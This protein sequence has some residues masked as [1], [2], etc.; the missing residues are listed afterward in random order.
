MKY[1][2]SNNTIPTT[3]ATRPS[4]TCWR[5]LLLAIGLCLCVTQGARGVLVSTKSGEEIRGFLI[6]QD[7]NQVIV[8]EIHADGTKA[9]RR[10]D[11]TEIALIVVTVS[12]ADLAT[13]KHDEPTNY[14]DLAEELAVKRKDPDAHHA[15]LRLYLIAAFLDPERLGRSSLLGMVSLAR[16]PAEERRF[17]AMLF[18]LDPDAD[19]ALLKEPD[20][21]R[22]SDREQVEIQNRLLAALRAL[23]RG[24]KSDALRIAQ[25]PDVKQHLQR[26][27]DILEHH[28][29]VTAC[30]PGTNRRKLNPLI[31]QKVIKLEL[32]ILFPTS[33]NPAVS[34]E[35]ST[36]KSWSHL[37]K[38]TSPGPTLPL[39]LESLTEFDPRK[40]L[41][42]NGAWIRPRKANAAP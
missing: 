40:S 30:T 39:R 42:R 21:F 16:N 12:A 13:L 35:K 18:L 15:A 8:D 22:A 34:K 25:R 37:F 4:S 32:A 6:R 36:G 14:R 26:Y 2:V 5:Q 24:S 31:L 7:D 29:L 11:R 23:R 20:R 28:E 19:R 17:R 1:S 33:P 41:F 3:S 27:E 38:R 10:I 9:R